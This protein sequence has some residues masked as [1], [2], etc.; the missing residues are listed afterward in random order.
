[1]LI[2]VGEKNKFGHPNDNV[3]E[4]FNKIGAT[5]YRTDKMGE[6]TI[7]VNKKGKIHIDKCINI[8]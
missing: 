4:R 7:N 1:M 3:I 5:I 6:I 2:G 8:P